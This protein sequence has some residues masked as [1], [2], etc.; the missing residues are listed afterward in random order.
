MKLTPLDIKKQEFS[1]SLRGYSVE[2]V[3]AFLDL[4]ARQLEEMQESYRRMEEHVRELE[5]RLMHYERIEEALQ[6]ALQTTRTNAAKALEAAERRASALIEEARVKAHSIQEEARQELKRAR[7]EAARIQS[8][9]DEIASRLQA[10]LL[11]ELEFLARFEGKEPSAFLKLLPSVGEEEWP[12]SRHLLGESQ[13]ETRTEVEPKEETLEEPAV[14]AR[15]EQTEQDTS[16]EEQ[17]TPRS[18]AASQEELER[19]RRIL[20]DLDME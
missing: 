19:I 17:E 5:N 3:H 7:Y 20:E 11:T 6:E 9:K 13:E 1:R 12:V 4:V 16:S 10:F 14:S 2:E 15:E 8:K 18:P